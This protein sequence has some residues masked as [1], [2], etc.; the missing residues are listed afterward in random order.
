MDVCIDVLNGHFGSKI[1][2]IFWLWKF[3][4]SFYG[5][6]KKRTFTV[7]VKYILSNYK[8]YVKQV[9]P[10][11]DVRRTIAGF[12]GYIDGSILYIFRTSNVEWSL[13]NIFKL[14]IGKINS[15]RYYHGYD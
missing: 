7:T 11:I 9:R 3:N 10:S 12:Y 14:G 13:K 8:L 15:K 5:N 2:D 6:L 1:D 4:L